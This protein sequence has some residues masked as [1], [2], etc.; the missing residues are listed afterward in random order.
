MV[1]LFH[2]DY[3]PPDPTFTALAPAA[4]GHVWYVAPNQLGGA[5]NISEA[6][7]IERHVLRGETVSWCHQANDW[8]DQDAITWFYIA[9]ILFVV[10]P[11]LIVRMR[12]WASARGSRSPL[13][14]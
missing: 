7:A 12:A 11:Y 8:V 3:G 10:L 5:R 14:F 13:R 2:G 6:E 9:A 1:C 4:K